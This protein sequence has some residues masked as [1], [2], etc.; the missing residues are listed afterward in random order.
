MIA[1]THTKLRYS[2]L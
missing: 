1:I 2:S